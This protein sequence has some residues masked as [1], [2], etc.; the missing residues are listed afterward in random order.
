[1]PPEKR[2]LFLLH[3][4]S[5]SYKYAVLK[6]KEAVNEWFTKC[7]NPY[8]AFSGG[9]DS[10]CILH[11]VR[12][13]DA[14]IP[15]VYF[16]ADCSFPEVYDVLN[17]TKNAMLKKSDEPFLDTLSRYG[18]GADDAKA[19]DKATMA[20]TVWNPIKRL[21]AEFGFDGV[22]YG[23]R[24]EESHGRKMNANRGHV[25]QY[26]RDGL[27]AC[28]PVVKWTYYDVWAYI[29]E[30]AINY[31]AVYDK[32]W[33]MPIEDQRVSYWAGETKRTHGRWAWLKRN[34]PDLFNKLITINPDAGYYM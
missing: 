30:N 16:D 4:R 28:Q 2:K 19:L 10:S 24:A 11:L 15:V 7:S 22:C 21:I 34:Y 13:V 5:K 23:L 31:C 29:V 33:D 17:G 25:F 12:S 14:N 32:M 26:K 8:I 1:M 9:K 6:A 3:T 20:S 27:W 18:F